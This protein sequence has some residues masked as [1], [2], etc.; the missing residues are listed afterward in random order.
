MIFVSDVAFSCLHEVL[1]FLRSTVCLSSVRYGCNEVPDLTN[2][3][4]QLLYAIVSTVTNLRLRAAGFERLATCYFERLINASNCDANLSHP[5]IFVCVS[6]GGQRKIPFALRDIGSVLRYNYVWF[7]Y[8]KTMHTFSVITDFVRPR[9]PGGKA[10]FI[11]SCRVLNYVPGYNEFG[12]VRSGFFFFFTHMER[13]I[14]QDYNAG[15]E[16]SKPVYDCRS[17]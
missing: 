1:S 3:C 4:L 7:C 16:R 5:S 17:T 2:G 9:V 11:I 13:V 10:T 12:V 15:H 6:F 8:K 14:E